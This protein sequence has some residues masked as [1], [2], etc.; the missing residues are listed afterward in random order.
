[1]VIQG[2]GNVGY[3]AAHFFE[4][5][6][7]KIIGIVEYNSSIYNSNGLQVDDATNYFREHKSFKDYPKAEEVKLETDY[8]EIMYKECD[9]LIPAAI[10]NTLTKYFTLSH[11]DSMLT[12]LKLNY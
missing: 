9:I 6:G 1:M 11:L 12:K 5:A 3:W 7:V 8:M 10:E 4:K 2:I